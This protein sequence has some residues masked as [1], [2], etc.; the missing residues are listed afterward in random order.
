M[1]EMVKECPFPS[2]FDMPRP[3]T[4]RKTELTRKTELRPIKSPNI[5][6]YPRVEEEQR[7][8]SGDETATTGVKDFRI[9]LAT[10]L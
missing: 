8:H 4:P 9:L 3:F 5:L 6:M 7:N 2:N 10:M 1:V